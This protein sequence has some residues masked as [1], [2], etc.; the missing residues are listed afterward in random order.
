M[1]LAITQKL[2]LD[3]IATALVT[4]QAL[5]I[6]IGFFIDNL[7]TVSI[8]LDATAKGINAASPTFFATAA[9]ATIYATE[10][11]AANIFLVDICSLIKSHVGQVAVPTDDASTMMMMMNPTASSRKA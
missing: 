9:D 2:R 10:A 7:A 1:S 6:W 8:L 5:A 11:T 4:D 3:T